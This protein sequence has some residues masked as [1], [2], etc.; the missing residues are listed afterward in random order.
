MF[1]S[2]DPSAKHVRSGCRTLTK[3]APPDVNAFGARFGRLVRSYR[4]DLGLSVRDLAVSVWNDEGRKASI[5]RLE[6]G[7]I[8]NPAARTVQRLAH[9]LDIPQD[10]I[11]DLRA[12]P[13]SLPSQLEGLSAARRDQL[14]A[15]A[16]RFEI[17]R[18]FERSDAELRQLLDDKATEYRVYKR[19][20]GE[21]DGRM[22]E[23]SEIKAAAREAAAQLDFE[24]HETLLRQIDESYS[25]MVVR[26]KEARAR[27]ALLRGRADEAYQGFVS[28][29]E[30]WR[31]LDPARSV[32]G[33][34]EYHRLLFEHS[35][36][37]GGTGLERS[38]DI[39]RPALE[40]DDCA[41]P[42]RARVLQNLANALANI[43]VRSENPARTRLMD[44]AT[45]RYEE[46]LSLVSADDNGD[47]W[48]MVQQ[49][50]G[51]ALSLRAE[52]CDDESARRAYLSRAIEA[53]RAALRL[54]P[55]D[56]KPLEWAMTTQ[57][58]AV[59]LLE[60]ARV[61]P[62][63]DGNVLLERA[64]RLLNDTLGV[65]SRDSAP[66]D[67]AL[68]QENLAIVAKAMAGRCDHPE[69]AGHLESA[70]CHVA[71][72]LEVFEAEGNTFY[73]EKAAKLALEIRQSAS[74][75]C[76]SGP[77]A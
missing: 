55:R 46:A 28:A 17:A 12:P 60:L 35:L 2:F 72:A 26:T 23:L 63:R 65:R 77:I 45:D 47:V 67:W 20:L 22:T 66:F 58:V 30:T 25:E 49:N 29:A 61:T 69:D 31:S 4:D 50:L 39:L 3:R 38:A 33:R 68:T 54:R 75:S 10:E 11:D 19:R 32:K 76:Q 14:E 24:A 18:V 40:T 37:F 27:H 59:V 62:G 51:A 41:A 53:F 43:G 52:Q 73:R 70:A 34:L 36:R 15:L 13:S 44:E 5:S 6:N 64:D 21:L 74:R 57:N 8:A 1:Q 42:C 9:A 16:S 7:H 71:A 56:T 48:A